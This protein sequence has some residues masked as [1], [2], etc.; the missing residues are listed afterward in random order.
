MTWAPLPQPRHRWYAAVYDP[1][2]AA[3]GAKYMEPLRASVVGGASGRVLE[4][5]CGTGANFAHYDWSKVDSL[6]AT[7]PDPFMLRR[8][9][10]K[11]GSVA[12]EP[13]IR[14]KVS[15]L[16]SPAESLPFDAAAFDCIVSTL[17]FCSVSDLPR[18]VAEVYRVLAPG[19]SLRFVEHVASTGFEAKVQRVIQPIYGWTAAECQLNR[20]TEDALRT[21]GFEVQVD[22]RPRL[23]PLFPCALGVATKPR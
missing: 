6:V 4:L 21:A 16:P 22:S 7:E 11:L 18:S 15:L 17:V 12:I 2:L 23:G 10:T 13:A 3:S 9:Q 14:A 5:G 19:G 1:L 8:A 20:H